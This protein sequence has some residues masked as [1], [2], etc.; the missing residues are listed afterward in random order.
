L[1]G[2][3]PHRAGAFASGRLLGA[4]ELGYLLWPALTP[5]VPRRVH[6]GRV[7]SAR[8]AP[9]RPCRCRCETRPMPC[10]DRAGVDETAR[11][12]RPRRVQ[13][14]VPA[15]SYS[16][17]VG[18]ASAPPSSSRGSEQLFGTFLIG[19]ARS[20][21]AYRCRREAGLHHLGAVAGL[22][23]RD[24]DRAGHSGRVSRGWDVAG[25]AIASA[26]PAVRASAGTPEQ[27]FRASLGRPLALEFR[28]IVRKPFLI[29]PARASGSVPRCRC[30]TEAEAG[31]P[32][33]RL[34][35]ALSTRAVPATVPTRHCRR[36][37][38]GGRCR[39]WGRP[40]AEPALAVSEE[41][42]GRLW[43]PCRPFLLAPSP[44]QRCRVSACRHHLP[45]VTACRAGS[46]M[47][48]APASRAARRPLA[49]EGAQ[50]GFVLARERHQVRRQPAAH[51]DVLAT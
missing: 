21:Q 32:T 47:T 51:H 27:L 7:L 36:V 6:R 43:R 20:R 1:F 40:D 12:G 46:C 28:T 17:A 48:D 2:R 35:A 13:L 24:A 16:C 9:G 37:G 26:G 11:C 8:G 23:C 33:A 30:E 50:V 4:C 34:S 39:D 38:P 3:L 15:F 10:R 5:G 45:A 18:P 42:E 41:G 31:P 29:G 14:P 22:P 44:E 49:Q 19:P 25:A